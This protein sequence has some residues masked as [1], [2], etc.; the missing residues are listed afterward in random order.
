MFTYLSDLQSEQPVSGNRSSF[1]SA[2]FE[3]NGRPQFENEPGPMLPQLDSPRQQLT[4]SSMFQ[5]PQQQQQQQMRQPPPPQS[6][7]SQQMSIQQENMALRKQ[8]ASLMQYMQQLRD[9]MENSNS[10]SSGSNG[11]GSKSKNC[12]FLIILLMVLF[13]V[14]IITLLV[15]CKKVVAVKA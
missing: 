1:A 9:S 14:V 2:Y 13:V 12:D 4:G 7:Q 5:Q 8:L 6:Q 10:K 15:F 11:D 3:K